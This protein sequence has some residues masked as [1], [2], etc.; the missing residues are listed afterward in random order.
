MNLRNGSCL[1]NDK[2]EINQYIFFFKNKKT[3]DVR[4]VFVGKVH[5][6]DSSR[7]DIGF[8]TQ[9]ANKS[10]AQNVEPL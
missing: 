1:W 8:Y 5:G 9:S 7:V 10:V 6:A 3:I 4:W 2:T